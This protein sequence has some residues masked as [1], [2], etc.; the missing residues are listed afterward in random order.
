MSATGSAADDVII[1][2]KNDRRAVV[3]G[4]FGRHAAAKGL[5]RYCI[6]RENDLSSDEN[7]HDRIQQ[8]RLAWKRDAIDGKASAFVVLFVSERMA[9]AVPDG[10]VMEFARQLLAGAVEHCGAF[11]ASKKPE[12]K[13]C[14]GRDERFR[15]PEKEGGECIKFDKGAPTSHLVS[16]WDVPFPGPR[17]CGRRRRHSPIGRRQPRRVAI[18]RDGKQSW[19]LADTLALAG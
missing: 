1:L 12:V 6:L 15:Q 2:E 4:L 9:A 11:V 14:D 18:K 10:T 3:A 17:Q 13:S 5:I 8:D 7:I 16:D 19:I